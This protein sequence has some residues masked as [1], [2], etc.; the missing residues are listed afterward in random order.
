MSS[1]LFLILSL[2]RIG[3]EGSASNSRVFIYNTDTVF[4]S[5]RKAV[6]LSYLK[7]L[8][9][10]TLSLGKNYRDI[11]Y[12]YENG[13]FSSYGSFMKD[14]SI[15]FTNFYVS[16]KMPSKLLEFFYEKDGK[17][18]TILKG[19]RYIGLSANLTWDNRG[20]EFTYSGKYG[21]DSKEPVFSFVLSSIHPAFSLFING[22]FEKGNYMLLSSLTHSIFI[23]KSTQLENSLN[24][25][26]NNI[27]LQT[28]FGLNY[29]KMGLFMEIDDNED[30]FLKGLAFYMLVAKRY[31]N[32][33]LDSE[34]GYKSYQDTFFNTNTM[35][36]ETDGNIT[37]NIYGIRLGL[38]GAIILEK[39]SNNFYITSSIAKEF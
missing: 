31:L 3:L 6:F 36:F 34:I 1:L 32:F 7:D 13:V 16:F 2:F 17:Y 33:M 25:Y 11:E 28:L 26:L 35:H 38:T 12:N 37:F 18:D 14:S 30:Y 23:T 20:I 21:I 29:A 27:K 24:L 5:N 19:G 39:E 10:F 22:I 9:Y 4:T 8:N 15:N